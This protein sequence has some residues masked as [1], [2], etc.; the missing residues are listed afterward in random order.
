MY[1]LYSQSAEYE[2][3]YR[4]VLVIPRKMEE[5]KRVPGITGKRDH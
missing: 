5:R 4:R 3:V 1:R 2:T